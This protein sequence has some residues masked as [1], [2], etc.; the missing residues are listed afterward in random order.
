MIYA[1]QGIKD[2]IGFLDCWCKRCGVDCLD[3]S[4]CVVGVE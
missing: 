2:N 3:F 1:V 4:E